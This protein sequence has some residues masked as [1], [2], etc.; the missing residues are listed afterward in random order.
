[1]AIAAASDNLVETVDELRVIVEDKEEF[2]KT[3]PQSMLR[4]V[5]RKAVEE[6]ETKQTTLKIEHTRAKDTGSRDS[7]SKH[8]S[9]APAIDEPAKINLAQ[10]LP[11][12]KR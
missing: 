5:L 2:E 11:E 4:S 12:G 1:M 7:V 10:D 3:F 6:A 8:S 9:K